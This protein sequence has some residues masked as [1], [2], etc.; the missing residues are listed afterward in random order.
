MSKSFRAGIVPSIVSRED[1]MTIIVALLAAF[2]IGFGL[3]AET[4][5]TLDYMADDR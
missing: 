4:A 3:L 2:L 5:P 1:K